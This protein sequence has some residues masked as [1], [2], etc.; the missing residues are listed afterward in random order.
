MKIQSKIAFFSVLLTLCASA[1]MLMAGN[2]VI[3]DLAYELHS[4][5][6][7]LEMSRA[8]SEVEKFRAACEKK[9]FFRPGNAELSLRKKII[10]EFKYL[11][12]GKSGEIFLISKDRKIILWPGRSSGETAEETFADKMF[13]QGEG[14]TEFAHKGERRF[15]TFRVIPPWN[16]LV[17][18]SLRTEEVLA[19]RTR[20]F[21]MVFLTG[22]ILFPLIIVITRIFSGEYVRRIAQTLACIRR[23]EKGD[24]SAFIASGNSRDEI[25]M[26]QQGINVMIAERRRVLEELRGAH[27]RM[28]DI[29]EFLPDATFVVD[30]DR[31]IIAWN[32]GMEKITGIPQSTV[33]GKG[34]YEYTFHFH[35][36]RKPALID[37]FWNEDPAVHMNYRRFEKKGNILY[38][39][40]FLSGLNRGKGAYLWVTASPLLDREGNL[41]GAIES[42]R[43]VTAHRQTVHMLELAK[44]SVDNSVDAAYWVGSDAQCLYVNQT[45]CDVLGYTRREFSALHIHDVDPNYPKE[46]WPETW[47]LIKKKKAF[48][49]ETCH[50]TK[51]GRV[52]PVEITGRYLE[53]EGK[54]YYF[55]FARDITERKKTE[56]EL[57]RHREHLEKLVEERTAELQK[58]CIAV[59]ESFHSLEKTQDELVQSRKMAALGGLVAGV[60]HEINTPVGIGVTA[61]SFIEEKTRTLSKR[62]A[63]GEMK[64]SDLEKYLETVNEATASLLT[65]LNRAAQLIRSFKQVAVDQSSGEKRVFRLKTYIEEVLLSLRPNYKKTKHSIVVNCPEDLELD[66][67]PGAFSQIITNLVMNS[68][69]HGFEGIESGQIRF[70][71]SAEESTLFFQYSDNGK[72]IPAEHRSRIFDPFFTTRRKGGGTGLGMH[73]V[74]NIVSVTLKGQ[75]SCESPQ[76]RGI[77]FL[78]KMPFSTGP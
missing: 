4:R 19:H 16:W 52:F 54:E 40:I 44:F 34:N 22:L 42:I 35:G 51:Q 55:C 58:A 12:Y 9:T 14:F 8:V 70:D 36:K 27:Q 11:P 3:S 21:R 15:C 50:R 67:Y 59:Q 63:S 71:I 2:V 65:N 48:T 24:M 76:D 77:S 73:I 56:T 49:I 60:A 68:L 46:K 7:S 31:K 64:R 74:Y 39:E 23:L 1:S 28:L 25:A 47:A 29:I 61:A 20:F 13:Q 75:I 18:I 10:S 6:L 72:G 5:M 38:A 62:Y 69:V 53:F 78:I 37:F 17:C 33:M 41:T 32:R 45:A 57:A 26:L 30:K 43:D 66:S